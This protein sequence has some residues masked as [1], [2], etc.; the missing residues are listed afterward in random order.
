MK[1]SHE[2]IERNV[3]LMM[4]L[5][6]LLIS[7]GGLVEIVPLFFQKSTTEP[8]AGLKPYNA[9]PAQ[10]KALLETAAKEAVTR[11]IEI[12]R[13]E[14][15]DGMAALKAKNLQPIS[16]SAHEIAQFVE[17]AGKPIW[18][19]WIKEMDSKGF[20]GRA[21]LDYVLNESKKGAS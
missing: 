18:D 14:E 6:I 3:G 11:H 5:I 20:P 4:V 8:V 10:Y 21:L 7:V 19:D 17:H 13:K 2:T 9:L 16:F 12:F 1:F 15:E